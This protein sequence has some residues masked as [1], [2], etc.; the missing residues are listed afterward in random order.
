MHF[1]WKLRN[2]LNE[3]GNCQMP[4]VGYTKKGIGP[5][6]FKKKVATRKKKII[7]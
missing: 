7:K 1:I 2:L 5:K 3:S 6:Q 4:N